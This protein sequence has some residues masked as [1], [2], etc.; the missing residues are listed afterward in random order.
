MMEKR[1]EE[2]LVRKEGE[3]NYEKRKGDNVLAQ[4]LR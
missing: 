1:V 4:G 2:R 3:T